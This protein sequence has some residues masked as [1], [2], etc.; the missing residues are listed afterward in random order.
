MS[1]PRKPPTRAE[2][3]VEQIFTDI[4]DRKGLEEAVDEM[5]PGEL[6]G[7][8]GAWIKI[9]EGEYGEDADEEDDGDPDEEDPDD[10]DEE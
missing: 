6:A 2:S 5:D 9:I 4:E 1:G 8:R 10:E 7:M 3:V